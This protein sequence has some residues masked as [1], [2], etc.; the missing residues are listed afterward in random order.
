[1]LDLATKFFLSLP[2][3]FYSVVGFFWAIPKRIDHQFLIA[4]L[5]DQMFLVMIM[6]IKIFRDQIFFAAWIL[7]RIA[8]KKGSFD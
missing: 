5:G 7:L 6:A 8:L 1:V 4:N 3:T 2:K